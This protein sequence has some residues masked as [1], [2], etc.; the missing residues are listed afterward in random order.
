MTDRMFEFLLA[1]LITFGFSFSFAVTKGPYA[2]FEKFREYVKSDKHIE[3][4][5]KVGVECPICLSFWFG[6]VVM[7]ALGGGVTM[8]LSSFGFTCLVVSLSPE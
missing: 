6:F 3:D 8:W 2:L 4:W 7:L 1:W 5:V